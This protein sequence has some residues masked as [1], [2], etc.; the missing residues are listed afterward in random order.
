LR[1][2][3]ADFSFQAAKSSVSRTQMRKIKHPP[4]FWRDKQLLADEG[5]AI[6]PTATTGGGNLED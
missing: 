6:L 5:P 3:L 1:E 2:A 4:V